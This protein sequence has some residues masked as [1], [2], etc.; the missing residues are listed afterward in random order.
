MA[1]DEAKDSAI[2]LHQ[3]DFPVLDFHVHLKG[4]LTF[5]WALARS[6]KLGINYA[7]APLWSRFSD[8]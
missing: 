1:I 4:G 8:K 7:I 5:D 2:R 6:R 3:R